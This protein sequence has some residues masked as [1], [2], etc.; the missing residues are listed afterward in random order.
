VKTFVVLF[1]AALSGAVAE[2]FFSYGMRSFGAMDWSK[3][4]RWIDLLLVVP[5]NPY[6]LT[7]VLFASG[8]FFLYLTALSWAD[9]SYAMPITALSFIFAAVF[10]Q[11][12]LGEHVS[13]HRWVGS[14]LIVA[15]VALVVLEGRPRGPLAGGVPT[16][17]LAGAASHPV[18]G[19]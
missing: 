13:W 12:F 2:T 3:P 10:A 7:G 1:F 4:A 8:F 16:A 19:R 5:R 9:L 6:V 11:V 14:L 18:E 15:G 17:G